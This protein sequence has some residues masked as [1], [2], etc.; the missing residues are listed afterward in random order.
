MVAVDGNRYSV[1]ELTRKRAVEVRVRAGEVRIYEGDAPIAV[2]PV[3]EG[4]GQRRIAA[5]QQRHASAGCPPGA[6]TAGR[7]GEAVAR[8]PLEFYEAVGRRRAGQGL[9]A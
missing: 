9:P 3:L 4:S 2:H 1:P 7:P 8:R 5:G 6:P